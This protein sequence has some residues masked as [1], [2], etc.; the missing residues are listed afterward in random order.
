MGKD[1]LG[2]KFSYRRHL[3]HFQP[4]G[5]TLFVTSRLAGSIPVEIQLQLQA[6]AA[7]VEATLSGMADPQKRAQQAYLEHRRLFGQWDAALH[8]TISGPFWLGQ[9]E[10]AG[11]VAQEIH[12]HD[13]QLYDLDAFCIMPNH[14]HLVFTPLVKDDDTC[15]SLPTIM[16]AI[17][18]RSAYQSNLLLNRRG[19]FWQHENYDHVVRDEAEW[20]RIITYTL[21]N[22]V[23][24]GWVQRWQDWPWS[25]CKFSIEV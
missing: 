15:H 10:I 5:A 19:T 25:Y 9:A 20:Q 11:L 2:Y 4:P 22:P 13:N 3:P 8:N 24:A 16:Q 21:N 17:K 23:K 1:N 6:V 12:R 14:M 18:G 7:K